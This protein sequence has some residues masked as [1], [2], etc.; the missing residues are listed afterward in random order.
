MGSIFCIKCFLVLV[1]WMCI[2]CWLFLLVVC[3]ISLCLISVL[4]MWVMLVVFCEVYLYSFFGV[5]L[6][7]GLL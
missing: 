5:E 1:I 3:M 4:F 2:W 6:L 7:L